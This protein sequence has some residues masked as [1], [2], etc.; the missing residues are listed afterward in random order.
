[1]ADKFQRE[2]DM[3]AS[4]SSYE[5]GYSGS[6]STNQYGTAT[7]CPCGRLN[8][9]S[10]R[11][12]RRGHA[13]ESYHSDL[14]TKVTDAYK[15]RQKRLLIILKKRKQ[16]KASSSTHSIS[17]SRKK[18]RCQESS[19]TTPRLKMNAE[20]FESL[21]KQATIFLKKHKFGP[22]NPHNPCNKR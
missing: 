1:M 21:K 8:C 7:Y 4:S 20:S 14:D 2:I 18:G 5:Y 11:K 16:A 3:S 6:S 19:S 9:G 13:S 15:A 12:A 10:N 17:S 22:F